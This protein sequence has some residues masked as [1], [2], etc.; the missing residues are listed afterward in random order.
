VSTELQELE[1]AEQTALARYAAAIDSMMGH[2]GFVRCC[3]HA[4]PLTQDCTDCEPS[5]EINYR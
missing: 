2:A 3:S 5:L 1:R 4:I